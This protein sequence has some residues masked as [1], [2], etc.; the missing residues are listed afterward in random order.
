MPKNKKS[1]EDDDEK[2]QWLCE[3]CSFANHP[4]LEICEMCELPKNAGRLLL[5]VNY[6]LL[7]YLFYL[8]SLSII[9]FYFVMIYMGNIVISF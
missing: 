3:K 7:I 1:V 5:L 9:L 2:N 4:A 6:A 8:I